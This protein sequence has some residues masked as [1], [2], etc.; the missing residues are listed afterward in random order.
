MKEKS[1]EEKLK[2][3]S[4]KTGQE[5]I[6]LMFEY[7]RHLEKGYDSNNVLKYLEKKYQNQRKWEGIV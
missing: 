1:I 4:E 5:S 2:E 6:N 3:I 7:F